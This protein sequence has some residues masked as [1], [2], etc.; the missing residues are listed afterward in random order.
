MKKKT[1]LA[2]QPA[3]M[4][5]VIPEVVQFSLL[6]VCVGSHM[7]Y[8]FGHRTNVSVGGASLIWQIVAFASVCGHGVRPCLGSKGGESCEAKKLYALDPTDIFV[9]TLSSSVT[10]LA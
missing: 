8:S 1:H 9:S 10:I 2:I 7:H 4:T 3:L 5:R 6:C